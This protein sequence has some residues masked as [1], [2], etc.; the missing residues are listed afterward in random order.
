MRYINLAVLTTVILASSAHAAIFDKKSNIGRERP[1]PSLSEQGKTQMV[2][3]MTTNLRA[4]Q[5]AFDKSN[6]N[7]N[8]VYF[9]YKPEITYKLRTRVGIR[10]LIHLEQGE[11][12][13]SYLVGNPKIF[14]VESISD[15]EYTRGFVP[16]LITVK[17]IYPGADTNLTIITESGRIYNFYL[18]SDPIDSETVPLFTVYVSFSVKDKIQEYVDITEKKELFNLIKPE[19]VK[20]IQVINSKNNHKKTSKIFKIEG[21][22]DIDY[23][24]T[25]EQTDNINPLYRIYGHEDIQP[26]AVYD[27]GNFTYF[28]YRHRLPSDR[29]PVIYKVVDGYDTVTNFRQEKGF[30]IAESISAE[31]WTLK[32]GKLYVCVKPRQK[33]GMTPRKKRQEILRQKYGN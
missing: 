31:G 4:V 3:P 33:P 26:F 32:N 7:E 28:D 29:L 19:K 12:I 30:L 15:K 5:E 6:P 22:E 24:S 25:L 23:L 1:Q 14:D 9:D 16:N 13:K 21:A 17:P 2:D 20:P 18:R 8:V 11:S 27:D 10:T